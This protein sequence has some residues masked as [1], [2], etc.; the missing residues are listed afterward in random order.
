M[1]PRSSIASRCLTITP[2]RAIA[3]APRASVT[4]TMAGSS[5]GEMPTARAT[6]NSSDSS[7]GRPSTWLTARTKNTITTMI[8]TRRYPNCRTPRANAGSAGRVLSRAATSPNAVA[9]PVFTTSTVAVPLRTD[10]PMKAQLVR[11]DIGAPALTAPGSFST[12]IDSPVRLA[13]V[14]RKSRAARITPSAGTRLPAA[15]SITSPGTISLA[16]TVRIAPSRQTRAVS[17]SRLRSSAMA[18]PARYSWAKP[19]SVLP[20]TIAR[21]IAA[22]TQSRTKSEMAAPKTRIRTSGLAN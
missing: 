10:V 13:S 1:L 19:R 20:S 18:A 15:S 12:G 14:T 6:A 5:S 22:S 16:T 2:R 3:R 17:A 8:R 9:R 4:L 7:A 21:M 11:P